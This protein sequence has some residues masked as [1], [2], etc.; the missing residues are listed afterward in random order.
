MHK[1]NIVSILVPALSILMFLGVYFF[2]EPSTTGLAVHSENVSKLV[3]AD[4]ILTTSVNEIIPPDAIIE[5]V[6]DEQSNFMTINNFIMKTGGEYEL[7]RGELE[8]FGYY[9]NGFTGEY[10]YKLSLGDFDLNRDIGKGEHKFVTRIIYR[11]QTLYEKEN[12]IMI[13]E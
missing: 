2:L 7:E 11:G 1:H 12:N 13:S 10:E 9:G 5:V 6:L 8:E 4:V 3:N